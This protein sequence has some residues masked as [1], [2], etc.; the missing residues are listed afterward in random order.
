MTWL[1]YI[2]LG[3]LLLVMGV[4]GATWG[5]GVDWFQLIIGVV[6]IA[7]GVDKRRRG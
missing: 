7:M 2:V 5:D 1:F 6:L 4:S 3:V